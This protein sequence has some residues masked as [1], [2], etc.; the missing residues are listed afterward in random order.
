MI[1]YEV[2]V[3]KPNFLIFEILRAARNLFKPILKKLKTDIQYFNIILDIIDL[4]IAYR[5]I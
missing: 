4:P 1:F 3:Y 2:F 5:R